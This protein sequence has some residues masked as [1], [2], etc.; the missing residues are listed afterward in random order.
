MSSDDNKK[1]QSDKNVIQEGDDQTTSTFPSSSNN[2]NPINTMSDDNPVAVA[3][4]DDDDD[5][6]VN[7]N[8]SP[9]AALD[10]LPDSISGSA[11][12][13][14]KAA[15]AQ[16][17]SDDEESAVDID[18]AGNRPIEDNSGRESVM[19][20]VGLDKSDHQPKEQPVEQ[21]QQQ[22]SRLDDHH[23][24]HSPPV[25]VINET[26]KLA[27]L[28][29][30]EAGDGSGLFDEV[31]REMEERRQQEEAAEELKRREA[32]KVL[33]PAFAGYDTTQ[34]RHTD[35]SFEEEEEDSGAAAMSKPRSFRNFFRPKGR[36]QQP[37]PPPR[38]LT[39]SVTQRLQ[40]KSKLRSFSGKDTLSGQMQRTLEFDSRSRRK[41]TIF[42]VIL[43]LCA[44]LTVLVI[45]LTKETLLISQQSAKSILATSE[46]IE[47]VSTIADADTDTDTTTDTSDTDSR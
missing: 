44:T 34:V 8:N 11:R 5:D 17:L 7:K 38:A 46:Y 36:R 32:R 42:F 28:L 35:D 26:T 21:Q 43:F 10:A 37:R 41:W 31:D 3:P 33:G 30:I 23:R 22:H 40:E 6:D 4:D 45:I 12:E 15:M 16:D 2:N 18:I 29:D 19:S 24:S 20:E 25:L 47:P 13:L 1:E 14:Y 27:G 9:D 39:K